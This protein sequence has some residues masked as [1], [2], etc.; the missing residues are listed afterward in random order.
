MSFISMLYFFFGAKF[1]K[2][3]SLSATS[4]PLALLTIENSP[5]LLL[6]YSKILTKPSIPFVCENMNNQLTIKM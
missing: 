4:L 5:S 2:A 3:T 1:D 6:P